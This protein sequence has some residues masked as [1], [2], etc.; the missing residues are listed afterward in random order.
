MI[1]NLLTRSIRRIKNNKL[2]SLI[3]IFGLG[4]GL[5]CTILM[6]TYVI[7]E[8]SFDKYHKNIDKIYRV[9]V[10]NNCST[11]YAMGEAFNTGIPE[12][13]NIFRIYNIWDAHVKIGDN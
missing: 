4:I 6:G 5:G 1:W 9:T 11:P 2:I 13:K 3:N 8:F 10:N 12:F 7:H